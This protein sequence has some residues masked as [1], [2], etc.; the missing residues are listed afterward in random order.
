MLLKFLD[1]DINLI[2]MGNI[3]VHNLNLA[4]E[5]KPKMELYFSKIMDEL[6]TNTNNIIGIEK[7]NLKVVGDMENA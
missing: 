4:K 6:I 3:L 1:K 7:I 2:N 5:S